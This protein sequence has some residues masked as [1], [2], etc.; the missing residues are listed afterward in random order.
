MLAL[1][2]A[3]LARLIRG[4]QVVPHGQRRKWLRG[5]AEK[6][7][8]PDE[9]RLT[10]RRRRTEAVRRYRKRQKDGTVICKVVVGPYQFDLMEKFVA[11]HPSL[12][13][14]QQA[15][16]AAL[17]RLLQLSLAVLETVMRER[18]V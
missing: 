10:R 5:I 3:S 2:D 9:R 17:E 8:P 16:D 11:L 1:D 4:A 7:D 13:R 18:R 14:D 12:M 15:V 6:F